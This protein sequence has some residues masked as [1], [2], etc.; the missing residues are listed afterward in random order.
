MIYYFDYLCQQHRIIKG[1]VVFIR[2]I[3]YV[4]KHVTPRLS[5]EAAQVLKQCFCSLRAKFGGPELTPITA[6]T[7]EVY[8]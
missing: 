5:A 3:C 7:L 1:F 2:Y 8:I 4:K 6:R